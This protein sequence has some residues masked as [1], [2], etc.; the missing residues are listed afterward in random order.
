MEH[1]ATAKPTDAQAPIDG[2]KWGEAQLS[3][4]TRF[5]GARYDYVIERLQQADYKEY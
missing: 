3:N 2:L 4:L 1:D 5:H